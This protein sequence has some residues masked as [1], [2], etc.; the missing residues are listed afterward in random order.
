MQV[1]RTTATSPVNWVAGSTATPLV[2]PARQPSATEN[3]T[4]TGSATGSATA[5]SAA[6]QP[7]SQ[8]NDPGKE[9]NSDLPKKQGK[10]A[11]EEA[12]KTHVVQPPLPAMSTSD[13]IAIES[14]TGFYLSPD[15]GVTPDSGTP[16]WS[17]IIQYTE[18]RHNS[19][20]DSS[21]APG[22]ASSGS[23][24]ASLDGGPH[25]DVRV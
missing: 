9:G 10:G 25:V 17:F 15:G 6:L 21:D 22:T 11:A 1:P 14:A 4:A 23:T 8:P 18:Q 3:A 19:A 2:T 7:A 13:R 5:A 20:S 12:Q 24:T 16:P